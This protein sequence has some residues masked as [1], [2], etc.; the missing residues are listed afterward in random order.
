MALGTGFVDS[1]GVE[2]ARLI[3]VDYNPGKCFWPI[4]SPVVK[5]AFGIVVRDVLNLSSFPCLF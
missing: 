1:G 2:I 3:V 5:L 4:R